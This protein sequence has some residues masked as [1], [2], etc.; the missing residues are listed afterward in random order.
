MRERSKEA[1]PAGGFA[2]ST[3]PLRNDS[4]DHK[5]QL[6]CVFNLL[7]AGVGFAALLGFV[8]TGCRPAP[9][10]TAQQEEGK[11]VY[12]TGCAHCHEE[13]DLHLKKVPPNLHGLFSKDRL[14]DGQPATDAAVEGVLM[15][16]KGMMPSFA[17]QLTKEQTTELLAYLHT[18]L[19]DERGE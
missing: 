16:G 3:F 5:I 1:Q 7:V 17:Y 2:I 15:S 18:G 6:G 14:P 8:L 4:D 10:L 12:D 13:N 9:R 19:R 11:H